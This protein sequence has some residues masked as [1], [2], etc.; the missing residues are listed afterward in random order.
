[1]G[2]AK[3]T[4]SLIFL[5]GIFAIIFTVRGPWRA[6]RPTVDFNDF[7]SPY[8]QS[9][10]WV[11]GLD[12]YD[13]ATLAQLW[14][15]EAGSS[16]FLA[17]RESVAARFGMPSPY[18]LTAFPLI[19]PLTLFSWRTTKLI[20]LAVALASFAISVMAS[21]QLAERD[22]SFPLGWLALAGLALAPFHTAIANGNPA[23]LVFALAVAAVSLAENEH[24]VWAALLL[25]LAV[26]LKPTVALPFA[27]YVLMRR[28]WR[29]VISVAAAISLILL[30][31]YARL[32]ASGAPWF[33][34][35]VETSRQMFGP[36]GID[37]FSVANNSR[38]NLL[39]F[40][41]V[42]SQIVNRRPAAQMVAWSLFGLLFCIWL[43]TLRKTAT[44][45]TGLLDLSFL[46][47]LTMLPLYH[48]FYDAVVLL[49]PIAWAVA[50]FRGTARRYAWLCLILSAPFILPGPALLAYLASRVLTIGEL[51]HSWAWNLLLMSHEIW[52]VFFL[53]GA[54]LA[55]KWKLTAKPCIPN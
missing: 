45:E 9:R 42:A 33:A 50:N 15:I 40:Q 19:A 35:F 11:L 22:G 37:D 14:P 39:N 27:L 52:A 13:P 28:H 17:D 47:A 36:G 32:T 12:P 6:L 48:R 30:L 18:P 4:P 1:M 21:A 51:S 7:L 2:R 16:S 8:L 41:V 26:G 54:L 38:F 34:S 20:W 23:L 46:A 5:L 24:P 31:A 44:R 10:G 53:S 55:A 43:W 3:L 25:T 49:V 29:V